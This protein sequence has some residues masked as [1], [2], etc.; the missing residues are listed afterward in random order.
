MQP[1][2]TFDSPRETAVAMIETLGWAPGR[3]TIFVQAADAAG[4]A[5]PPTAVFVEVGQPLFFP[6]IGAPQPQKMR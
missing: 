6:Y 1:L 3:H 2:D 5:G 4:N